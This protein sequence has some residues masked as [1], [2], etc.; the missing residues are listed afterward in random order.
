Y[1]S[2]AD[3][4]PPHASAHYSERVLLLPGLGT[5]YAEPGCRPATR[6]EFGLP[7]D[8]RLYACPQSLFKIHPDNDAMF[9]DLLRRD[10][11]ARL[12]FCAQP[13]EP[14]TAQFQARVRGALDAGGV[15]FNHVIWQPLRPGSDFRAL[16]SVCDVMLDTL[17]W[18]GGNTSLDALAA[19]LPIVTCPGRFLRGRQSAAM[20][21]TLSLESLI[22]ETPERVV[23]QAIAVACDSKAAVRK[24][25]DSGAGQLFSRP[26]AVSTLQRYLVQITDWDR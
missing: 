14:A 7:E 1:F 5:S 19:R 21:R 10:A 16:L 20:L 26:E 13:A 12:V 11:D 23:E 17:H 22:V 2:C 6:S 15:D 25:I 4:E 24:Q 18:S 8:V 3:M 9:A